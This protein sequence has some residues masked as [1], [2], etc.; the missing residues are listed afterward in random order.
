MMIQRAMAGVGT[1]SLCLCAG[2]A[3]ASVVDLT[4]ADSV[5]MINGARFET[6]D[7]RQ[8][9]VGTVNSFVR[10]QANGTERGYNTSG[11][12]LPFNDIAS[13]TRDLTFGE[14]PTRNIN[15]VDY[16]E[17]VLNIN[18]SSSNPLL[19]LDRVQIFKSGTGGQTTTNVPS[20]GAMVYDMDA[21]ANSTVE[22]DYSVN[23]GDPNGDMRFY[24]PVSYFGSI[25]SG[26]YLYLYSEW[27]DPNASNE[28]YEQWGVQNPSVVPL[29]TSAIAGLSG[30]AGLALLRVARRRY[31]A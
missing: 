5:G 29:P 19:S 16:K 18:Q 1:L 3:N 20:L 10:I 11:S 21:G 12:N 25:N 24:V 26:T 7:Y 28:G 2:A 8:A 15:G 4:H 30:L 31:P 17:F 6:S 22:L 14:V 9:S 23:S 27:G 13:G